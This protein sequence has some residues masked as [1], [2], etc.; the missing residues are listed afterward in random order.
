MRFVDTSIALQQHLTTL[1][2]KDTRDRQWLPSKKLFFD[3]KGTDM[4]KKRPSI[5]LDVRY[6]STRT[7][8]GSSV[9][10]HTSWTGVYCHCSHFFKRFM[11]LFSYP[12]LFLFTVLCNN[13][14]QIA[15]G[16]KAAKEMNG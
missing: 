6:S 4:D 3:K 15:K 8:N 16:S 2:S 13:F 1:R 12:V 9:F 7:N 14:M 5:T 11:V 10:L